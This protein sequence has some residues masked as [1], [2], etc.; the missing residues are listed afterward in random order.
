VIPTHPQER[1]SLRVSLERDDRGFKKT[2]ID[3]L[4]Q[5][6]KVIEEKGFF[7]SSR[8]SKSIP[9]KFSNNDYFLIIMAITDLTKTC[10]RHHQS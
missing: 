4:S 2:K 3:T 8:L 7:K 1:H 6:D 5:Y 9:I 10:T